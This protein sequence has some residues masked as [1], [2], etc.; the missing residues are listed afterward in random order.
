[1]RHGVPLIPLGSLI[2]A[3]AVYVLWRLWRPLAPVA[4]ALVVFSNIPHL[5]FLAEPLGPMDI[6]GLGRSVRCTLCDYVREQSSERSADNTTSNEAIVEY[7]KTVPEGSVVM[8]YP[9]YLTYSPMFYLP[10]L[11]YCCQLPA[12]KEIRPEIKARLPEYLFWGKAQLD[13]AIIG[14]SPPKESSGPMN[15]KTDGKTYYLG[16]YR[17]TGYLDVMWWDFSRPEIPWRSFTPEEVGDNAWRG[18]FV[19]QM[20]PRRP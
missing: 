18:F 15:F 9:T 7:L 11:R 17:L 10:K 8:V 19:A 16:D 6:R 14:A 13:V 5:A 3:M 2:A 4:L 12:D 20:G 1:M